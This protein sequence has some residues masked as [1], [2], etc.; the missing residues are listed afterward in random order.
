MKELAN[1]PLP[2][3]QLHSGYDAVA[4]EYAEKFFNELQHKPCDR[5]LLSRFTV[6]VRNLGPV[7]DLGCGPGQ[8][9][10]Y[11]RDCGVDAF[12]IDLSPAMIVVAQRLNPDLQFYQGDMRSL[13]VADASWGGIAAFYSIIHIPRKKVVGA[14]KELRRVLK[15]S[16]LLLLSFHIGDEIIR[17]DEWW[18][19]QVSLDFY[20][21][22][23]GEMEGYLPQA[24]FR[25]EETLE[26][27]LYEAVE[28]PSRRGYIMAMKV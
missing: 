22:T 27:E 20:F 10:R 5:E 7:C 14:L 2:L 26:R 13:P 8:I 17:L 19:K 24:G 3:D 15:P 25:I 9:A 1:L 6:R 18:D 28:H 12:G 23:V 16:G 4:E 21:F 11:L